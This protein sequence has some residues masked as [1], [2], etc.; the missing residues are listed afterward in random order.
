MVD[1]SFADVL[2]D[3]I[4]DIQRIIRSEV[5]LAKAELREEISTLLNGAILAGVGAILC[6]F[7]TLFLLLTILYALS[8][9][10]PPW[11]AAL[12]VAGVMGV[13]AVIALVL[14]ARGLKAAR[15]RSKIV[16]NRKENIEWAK[17]Q[18]K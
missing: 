5:H 9:W 12:I 13:G 14:A 3:I 7:A 6:L 4:L 18:I 17:Q 16:R 2:Q 15:P 10:M 11:T 1:R 8:L